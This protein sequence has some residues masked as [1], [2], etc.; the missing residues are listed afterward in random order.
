V[1]TLNNFVV[2]SAKSWPLFILAAILG[3]ATLVW[4][5]FPLMEAFMEV[6]GGFAPFDWQADLDR[7]AIAEQVPAYKPAM[8]KIYYAHTAVDFVFPVYMGVFFGAVAAFFLRVGT[9]GLFEFLS[10]KG[11]FAVFLIGA[12]F[13]M[14]ENI[15]ALGVLWAADT[16][17]WA[18]LLIL[19]KQVKL[20][21]QQ[22]IPLATLI[23]SVVGIGG[24]IRGRFVS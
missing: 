3:P 2:L 22:F 16:D 24:W 7:Q 13:D 21:T 6:S 12:P 15:G 8:L 4:V 23:A 20:V 5:L 14:L 1:R 19:A 18:T 11:L 17:P 10:S 9:P